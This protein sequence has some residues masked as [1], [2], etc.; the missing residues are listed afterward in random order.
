MSNSEIPGRFRQIQERRPHPDC[1]TASKEQLLESYRMQVEC[2][3]ISY[4]LYRR[5]V[6]VVTGQSLPSDAA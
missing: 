3:A 6:A 2:E 1:R 5:L 4:E